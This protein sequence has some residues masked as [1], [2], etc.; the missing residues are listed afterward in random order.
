M[1]NFITLDCGTTNTRAIL[2]DEKKT[3]R[4]V[5]KRDVGVRDTAIDRGNHKLKTAVK[6]C[7]N[8][9]LESAHMSFADIGLII[10]SGMITSNVGLTEIP[11]LVAPAGI[12]E[13]AAATQAVLLEDVCPLPIHFIP[14]IK[15]ISGV[16]DI[17]QLEKMDI[18]RGEEVESCAIIH[19]CHKGVPMLLVL[20]GS[21]T[22]FVA[23]D[24]AGMITGCL[25]TIT[26]ELLSSITHNT[27]IA[28][29]VGHSFVEAKTY[30]KNML[31]L[32]YDTAKKTG[33]G[34]ACFSGRI[35][36]QFVTK[37]TTKAANFIFGAVLQ[38]DVTAILNSGAVHAGRSTSVIVAGKDPFRQAFIDIL[39]HE[40]ALGQVDTFIPEGGIPLSALGAIAVMEK[41]FR[42]DSR[43]LM[44][45]YVLRTITGFRSGR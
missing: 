22:K 8:G 27:I 31:L 43:R 5:E 23:V 25:T 11:H 13:L 45:G 2:W 39:N 9:L 3:I 4:A 10:A 42:R 15:N 28:D 1:N 34:R 21:H 35:L 30:D 40:G 36:N 24:A 38:N 29:A 33:I 37:D 7:I 6:E 18:M 16:S 32:G 12:D 17:A 19:H 26:G 41:R 20:P 14:G 44:P